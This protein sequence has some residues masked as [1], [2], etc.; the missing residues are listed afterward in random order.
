MDQTPRGR[1]HKAGRPASLFGRGGAGTDWPP[2]ESRL[3]G[4]AGAR[5]PAAS[6]TPL[7]P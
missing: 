2:G 6:V 4:P 5:F 3:A 1:G 7:T